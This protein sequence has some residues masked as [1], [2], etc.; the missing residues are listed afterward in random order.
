MCPRVV[1]SFVLVGVVFV[2]AVTVSVSKI[3][4]FGV[5]LALA[6]SDLDSHAYASY[7]WAFGFISVDFVAR[8][9]ELFW[10]AFRHEEDGSQELSSQI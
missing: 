6:A 5:R 3:P 4:V 7:R 9:V 8:R 1:V 10:V 2:F